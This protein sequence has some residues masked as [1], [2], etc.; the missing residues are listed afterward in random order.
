MRILQLMGAGEVGGAETFAIAMTRGLIARGHVAMLANTWN[1]SPFNDAA[2]AAEIP[3]TPLRGGRRLIGPRWFITV[4]RFLRANPFDVVMTYGTR[5]SVGLRIM[6]RS[7]GVKH[8]VMGIRGLDVHRRRFEA[9]LDARTEH[10]V[11]VFVCNAQIVADNRRRQIG[12][13][14][15]RLRVIPNGIDLTRFHPGVEPATRESV[16]LPEGFLFV[17]VASFRSEKDHSTLLE[18]IRRAGDALGDAKFVLVGSGVL[19]QAVESEARR[20]GPTNRVIFLGAVD[21]VRP[22]VKACDAF[23]LSSSAEGMPRAVMEAMALGTPVVSTAAGGVPE[24]AE[25][26]THALIV[27]TRDP[28]ALAEALVRM[29]QDEGLRHRLASSAA[30][31]IRADFDIENI[32]DRYVALFGE[33]SDGPK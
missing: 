6:R 22:L 18:A 19:Q 1:E 14:E 30:E 12:T 33:L 16:G 23:V 11:D 5:I 31:R 9:L 10:L 20:L 17:M 21:D 29:V 24:I 27:P 13:N 32:I 7:V 28:G 2:E 15:S 26:E 25:H 3:F 8:H 4:A